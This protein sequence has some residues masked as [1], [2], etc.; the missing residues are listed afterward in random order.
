MEARNQRADSCGRTVESSHRRCSIKKM[1]L[2]ILQCPHKTPALESIFKKVAALKAELFW[3]TSANGCFFTVSMV[4]CYKA[5]TFQVLDCMKVQV[6][7]LV[8]T[9]SLVLNQVPTW[10]RK[11][12]TKA[13]DKSIKFWHWLFFVGLDGFRSF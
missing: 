12:K 4:H 6:T 5:L 13:I 3:A 8:F 9:A 2:K 1:F 11:P 7:D 10:V